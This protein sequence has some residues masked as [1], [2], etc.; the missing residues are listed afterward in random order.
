M[1]AKKRPA[2][3]EK[4]KLLAFLD[5]RPAVYL[6][7][8][9]KKRV[10]ERGLYLADIRRILWGE[11]RRVYEPARDRWDPSLEQWSYVFQGKGTDGRKLRVV[12]AID[13]GVLVVTVY[14][15]DK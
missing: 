13:E 15:L 10:V 4:T 7:V 14:G 12:I 1:M 3:L 6:T 8:H 2:K 5:A 11:L 9:G